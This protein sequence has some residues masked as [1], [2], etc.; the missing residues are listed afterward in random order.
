MA[1]KMFKESKV[2]CMLPMNKLLPALL[3]TG[4]LTQNHLLLGELLDLIQGNFCKSNKWISKSSGKR[5]ANPSPDSA[6]VISGV[7]VAQSLFFCVVFCRSLFVL[8]F[9]FICLYMSLDLVCPF[10]LFHLPV[11]VLGFSVPFCSFSFA[12]TCPSWI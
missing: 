1:L 3:Q 2:L 12:C 5:T 11:H 10:V 7:H 6:P 9:F 8:L 4:S